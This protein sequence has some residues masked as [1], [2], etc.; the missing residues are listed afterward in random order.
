[1]RIGKLSSEMK[2][3]VLNAISRSLLASDIEFAIVHTRTRAHIS[4]R[5]SK[6]GNVKYKL[7]RYLKSVSTMA[8]VVVI[9]QRMEC[10]NSNV[11][12]NFV[13]IPPAPMRKALEGNGWF[14]PNLLV[15]YIII[16]FC[17]V[18]QTGLFRHLPCFFACISCLWCRIYK[19]R[20]HPEH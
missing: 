19:T 10:W 9:Q 13:K 8:T 12:F 2:D 5:K 15:L 16:C 3:R 4:K 11:L 1:M 18:I 20:N 14:Y 6:N 7:T 17:S